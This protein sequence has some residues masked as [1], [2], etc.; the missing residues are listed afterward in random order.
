MRMLPLTLV[1]MPRLPQAFG[2]ENSPPPLAGHV[3]S[4][5]A[6]VVDEAYPEWV[7]LIKGQMRLEIYDE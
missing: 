4:P 1:V 6:L 3:D 7:P 2:P 5:I